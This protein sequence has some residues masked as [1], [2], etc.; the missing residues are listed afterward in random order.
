VYINLDSS[1]M[2]VSLE[3]LVEI[4]KL[5]RNL[6]ERFQRQRDGIQGFNEK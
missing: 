5:V 4:K 6:R 2:C 1:D 3:I